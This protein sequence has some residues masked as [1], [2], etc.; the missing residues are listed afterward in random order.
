[1][2]ARHI[3]DRSEQLREDPASLVD[4]LHSVYIGLEQRLQFVR[5]G[6]SSE[7]MHVGRVKG[8]IDVT[9]NHL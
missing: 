3:L 4:P 1:M 6:S 2:Q 7:L 8:S 9:D 5:P